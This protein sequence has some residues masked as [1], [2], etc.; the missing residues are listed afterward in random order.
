MA[1]KT[2]FILKS[3]RLYVDNHRNKCGIRYKTG[4]SRKRTT[5][6]L[7]FLHELRD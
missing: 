3:Y 7:T 1:Y 4:R 2:A 6:K 5:R